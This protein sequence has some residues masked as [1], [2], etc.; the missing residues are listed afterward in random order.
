MGVYSLT[1]AIAY[2]IGPLLGGLVMDHVNPYT[3]WLVIF[4]M[5]MVVSLA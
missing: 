2:A 1:F 5:G 4:G 3:L